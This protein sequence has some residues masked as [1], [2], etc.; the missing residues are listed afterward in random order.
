[1][2]LTIGI[3]T[4]NRLDALKKNLIM[5]CEIIQKEHFYDKVKLL[6]SDNASDQ[7]VSALVKTIQEAYPD[8]MLRYFRQEKNVGARK[9]FI[10]I[11]ELCDSD[12][13]MLMGDDDFMGV[14]YLKAVL[15]KIKDTAVDCVLP[16]Y[17]NVDENGVKN[18]R[19]RDLG[20]RSKLYSAGYMN[21]LKNSWRGHQMSGLVVKM[22]GLYEQCVNKKID[23]WY[24]QIYLVAYCCMHG[25]T[26][27]MCD[28]PIQVT[29]PPQKKKTWGYGEDGLISSIFNNYLLLDEINLFQRFL[30]EAKILYE[31]YWRIAMYLKRGVGSF[32]KCI[33]SIAKDESTSML[34]KFLIWILVP[35]IFLI[36]GIKLLI[37][38]K[39]FQTLKTKVDI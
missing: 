22:A 30:L 33:F 17:Y 32:L 8:I 34:M 31:Q 12:Y 2:L 18:G 1:M 5:L 7:D 26:Y 16:A 36:Q 37:T 3:P 25:N 29:R 24:L 11:L 6:I 20:K 13:L 27:H 28:D 9:N 39:L 10:T 19:G 21:C 23:N 38:G 14:N 4:Y 15:N 35:M